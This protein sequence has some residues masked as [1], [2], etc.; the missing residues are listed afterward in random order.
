M[1]Y[2]VCKQK[3]KGDNMQ[4]I[5]KKDKKSK[6]N[7]KSNNSRRKNAMLYPIYKIFAWDLLSYYS[8]EYLFLT[9]TK[10]VTPS[11]VLVISAVY[12]ISKV[13]LQI[14][15]VIISEYLGKRKSIIVGNFFVFIYTILLMLSPNMFGICIAE[16]V[17]ALGYDIKAICDSNL[18]YDSV[19]TKGGDGLYTKLEQ[20]GG[21]GYYVLDA[22][23]SIMAGYLFVIN[24]YIPMIICSVCLVIS[25]IIS[26]KFKDIYTVKKENRKSVGKFIKEY[27]TDIFSSLKFIKRSKRIKSY[28]LFGVV[29]FGVIR[30]L[31]TYKSELLTSSGIEAEQF[32]I[33]IAVLSLIAAISVGFAKNIQN[34]FKNRTLS[35]ISLTYLISWVAIGVICLTT[36][37]NIALPL[38]LM[39][40]VVNR[41]CDSQW[42]ITRGKYLRNFTEPESRDKITFIFELIT[43]LA[44]GLSALIGAAILDST[45]IKHAILLVALGGLALMILVLDYMR[46]RFGLKPK[47]YN[48]ED[49]KFVE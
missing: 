24:N 18:L 23:L 26:F 1:I 32:S 49:I 21:S 19:A 45:D 15:A 47:Q 28:I 13:I 27:K 43:S 2:K 14:P 41:I 9:I 34:K 39:L 37:K 17:C 12:V 38:V 40:Y 31:D 36:T 29:F 35:F 44:A 25:L 30:I 6:I 7:K 4:V 3:K 16:F 46:T 22:A 48:D 11:Q 10:G 5:T 42:Y 33:I 20:K 8:I